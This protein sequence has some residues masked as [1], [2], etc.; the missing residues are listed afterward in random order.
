M[1]KKLPSSFYN[2]TTLLGTGLALLSFGLIVFLSIIEAF[3]SNNKPYAGIL[4]FIILP[5]FLIIGLLAIAYGI[6][7][8]HHLEKLGKIR[9]RIINCHKSY[10]FSL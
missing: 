10:P 9:N 6:L 4:T 5:I 3:N 2:P 8:E 7:R 1:R